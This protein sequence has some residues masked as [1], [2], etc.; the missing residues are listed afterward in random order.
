[1]QT[2]MLCGL[3]WEP[4]VST[5]MPDLVKREGFL[6][7]LDRQQNPGSVNWAVHRE[8]GGGREVLH[9]P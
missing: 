2:L 6:G 4:G 5:F 1:M 8:A 7:N 9:L 3:D